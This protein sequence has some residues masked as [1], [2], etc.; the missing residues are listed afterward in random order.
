MDFDWIMNLLKL[1]ITSFRNQ[2]KLIGG[3]IKHQLMY[4]YKIDS[5]EEFQDLF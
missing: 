2:K 4:M 3:H 5:V 1:T